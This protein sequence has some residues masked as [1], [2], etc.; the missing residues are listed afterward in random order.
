MVM[1]SPFGPSWDVGALSK[2]DPRR[3]G[4]TRVY[5]HNTPVIEELRLS[6]L[7][8]GMRQRMPH[9]LMCADV[10]FGCSII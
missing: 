5:L 3:I 2:I 4:I 1:I 8:K 9:R 7:V 6:I 10:C